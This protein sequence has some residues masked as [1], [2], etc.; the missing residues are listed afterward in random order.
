MTDRLATLSEVSHAQSWHTHS[1]WKPCAAAQS[2]YPQ[3]LLI[4]SSK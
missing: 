1:G 2:T 4:L 3:P